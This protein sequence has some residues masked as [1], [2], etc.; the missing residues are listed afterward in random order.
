MRFLST[1]F[2][3]KSCAFVLAIADINSET[4]ARTK[5][6]KAASRGGNCGDRLTRGEASVTC[7]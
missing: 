6:Q 3:G 5:N 4:I 1:E 2:I 7:E